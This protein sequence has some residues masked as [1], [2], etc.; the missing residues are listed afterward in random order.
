MKIESMK[1]IDKGSIKAIF[2]L[3]LIKVKINNCKL[4]Q[5]DGK[6]AFIASPDEK[7]TAKNGEVKYKKHIVFVDTA[8]ADKAAA[9]ALLEYN[10]LSVP[11]PVS[12]PVD[13]DPDDDIPF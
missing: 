5:P 12:A 1:V 4:V 11:A 3:D 7:F 9:L 8:L 10:K 6:S 13:T 2:T